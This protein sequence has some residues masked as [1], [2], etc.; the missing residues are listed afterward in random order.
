MGTILRFCA[1][2]PEADILGLNCAQ[3][4]DPENLLCAAVCFLAGVINAACD[5]QRPASGISLVGIYL[6]P[7]YTFDPNFRTTRFVFSISNA[8]H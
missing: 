3:A 2:E 7:P 8:V 1:T 6:F 5:S 4:Q